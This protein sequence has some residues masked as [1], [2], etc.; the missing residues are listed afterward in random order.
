MD[1]LASLALATE[2]PKE[3]LL[4]RPP[5]HKDEYIISRKMVKHILGMS[6]YHIIACYTVVFAG[7]YFYPEPDAKFRFERASLNGYLYPGRQ[8]DWDE[9]PLYVNKY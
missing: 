3:E 1:S 8:Y 2:P 7:E 5:Y 6:L 9:K 4:S